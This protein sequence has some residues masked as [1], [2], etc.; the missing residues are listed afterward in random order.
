MISL[1][2]LH[3][4]HI[5][6]ESLLAGSVIGSNIAFERESNI[7]IF[8]IWLFGYGNGRLFLFSQIS[9]CRSSLNWLNSEPLTCSLWHKLGLFSNDNTHFMPLNIRR[10]MAF[11]CGNF[12]FHDGLGIKLANEPHP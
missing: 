7:D 3:L 4:S 5:Q 2:Y 6:R 9:W 8:Q 12:H 11:Y 1:E 10:N